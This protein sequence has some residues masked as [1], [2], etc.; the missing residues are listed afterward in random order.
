L[1]LVP[2]F[3]WLPKIKN[4]LYIS[5]IFLCSKHHKQ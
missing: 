4:L 2:L 3:L 5:S 1:L